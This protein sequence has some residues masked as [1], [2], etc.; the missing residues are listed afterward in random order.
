[1]IPFPS[2]LVHGRL[3]KRYLRFLADV[4][5]DDKR[6]VVA[7][8]TNS[9]SMRSCLEQGAEVY[10]SPIDNPARKTKFT[11]EM[12]KI[13]NQWVGINTSVPNRV[14]P[15]LMKRNII[16]GL[17]GYTYIRREVKVGDSRIDIYA[18][19]PGETCF[20]EVKNVTL[21]QDNMALF[22]DAVTLRGQKHLKTLM[23]LKQKGIRAV[24]L[25]VIQR[26]DV[27]AFG[28]AWDIDPVYSKLLQQALETGVEVIPVQLKVSPE[29]VS[30]TKLL[31]VRLENGVS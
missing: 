30:Y 3:M 14:A 17:E 21:R 26:M 29:G 15:E 20:I 16:P 18:E 7:H 24:M 28:P 9:G 13:N 27:D 2:S 31:P 22:P 6:V 23:E 8:C 25:Y 4:Q 5:L 12:I 10:L 1:M 19:K 11:W